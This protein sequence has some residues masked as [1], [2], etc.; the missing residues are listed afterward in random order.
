MRTGKTT[1][2]RTKEGNTTKSQAIHIDVVMMKPKSI[3]KMKY[4]TVFTEKATSVRWAYFHESTNGPYDA[5][6]IFQKMIKTQYKH[7]MKKWRMDGGKEYSPN[8]LATLAEDLGQVV[9]L[10]TPYTPEQDGTSERSIGIIC[11]RTR[12]A[13]IDL[14]IPPFLWT[15]IFSSMVM[16]TNRTATSTID[17]KTPYQ[18]FMDQLYPDQDN[19]PSV[20]HFRVLGCKTYV[21]MPKERRV[22]SE[23]VKERA[24]VGILV[25][26]E[27]THIFK[28]YIPS[29]RNNRDNGIV[30]SS[31]VR[32]DEGGLVTKPLTIDEDECATAILD[33]NRGEE[34]ANQ[35]R[36]PGVIHQTI[37]NT[38]INLDRQQQSPLQKV[39][40][41]LEELQA[42]DET[43]ADLANN[44]EISSDIEDAVLDEDDI[45]DIPEVTTP[46]PLPPRAKSKGRP[47]GSKNKVHKLVPEFQRQ[48][49][50]KQSKQSPPPSPTAFYTAYTAASTSIYDDPET[51]SEAKQGPDWPLWKK[52]IEKEYRG[53]H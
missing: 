27:G 11:E 10:T 13:I 46:P 45:E 52:A 23:K 17:R 20:A 39:V 42:T 50:S 25:G 1:T 29:K 44:P 43:I 36:E 41:P 5:L 14:N 48:T 38:G 6:V 24:E 12:T 8:K 34:P 33:E 40:I 49:R 51:V 9:E 3:G 7:I 26:Y 2:T 16:I 4:A 37:S 31:N 18:A 47:K 21:Q 19:V 30:R 35:D 32:F 53:I 22:L 15:H 28:V